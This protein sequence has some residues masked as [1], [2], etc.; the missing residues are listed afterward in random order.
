MSTI[1]TIFMGFLS[2]FV[3]LIGRRV[4]YNVF[5]TH[6]TPPLP[7]PRLFCPTT[8]LNFNGAD[9]KPVYLAVRGRVFDVTACKHFYGPVSSLFQRAILNGL[10]NDC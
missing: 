3:I 10:G 1:T 5:I 6:Q 9:G 2:F 4:F 8:L 7:V